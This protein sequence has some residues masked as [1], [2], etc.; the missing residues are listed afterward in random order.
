MVFPS[1]LAL[2]LTAGFDA[3][4][5]NAGVDREVGFTAGEE[6]LVLE[7]AI[8]AGWQANESDNIVGLRDPRTLSNPAKVDYD[9]LLEK[10]DEMKRIKRD[11]I[12]PNSP[13]GVQLKNRARQRV[14]DACERVMR[15]N[16]H[17]SVWKEISHTDGRSVTDATD[18]VARLL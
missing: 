13:Q 6:T 17:C 18:S 14:A 4:L 10:T 1:L 3:G 8:Q 16:G 7:Q 9:A 15:D 12:D 11:R 5:E 2:A